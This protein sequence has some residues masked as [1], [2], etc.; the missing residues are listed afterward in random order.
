[1][2]GSTKVDPR[3]GINSISCTATA[4]CVTADNGGYVVAGQLPLP[5]TKITTS[6]INKSKHSATFS[7][8]APGYASGFQCELAKKGKKASYSSCISLNTYKSLSAGSYTFRVRAVNLAGHD[9]A[10][11]THGFTL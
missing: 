4:L 11:A 3:Y 6:T 8:K 1:M 7:F 2:R 5:D 9:P 10:P